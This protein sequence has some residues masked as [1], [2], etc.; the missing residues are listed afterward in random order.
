LIRKVVE[1]VPNFSEGR[2]AT[3]VAR[4]V[5][6]IS[7]VSGAVVMGQTSDPD[8]N[9]SVITFAGGTGPV[10]EAAFRGIERAVQL[11]DLTRQD[12]V[13]PCI[14][15]A[16]VV[17]LVPISGL[18]I[19]ECARLAAQ[20][21]ERVW[22][23]L[24]VPVYLYEAAARRPDRVNLANIRRGRF[25]GLLEEVRF[26]AERLP[27]FGEAALHPTAGASVIGARKFL[28]A[29]NVNLATPDVAIA[30]SIARKIRFSSGGLPAVR[31]LGLFL[32][33]R[34]LAQVSI[35]LT[36]FEVTPLGAV[37]EAIRAEAERR[38]VRISGAELIGLIPRKALDGA[39]GSGLQFENFHSDLI[40]ENR[41]EQLLPSVE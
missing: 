16:D 2:D 12:G 30:R 27:D 5:E 10:L 3:V 22:S 33:S 25:A 35:N 38:H 40:L 20:L 11:I 34:R 13:H 19:E 28:I 6:A 1:C 29:F 23:E 15:A 9:R 14:G 17:P 26:N 8:H 39:A 41:L 37:F 31:A 18:S 24:H 36:D 4:I 21:G 7:G 32:H